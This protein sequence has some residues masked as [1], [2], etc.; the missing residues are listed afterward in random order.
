MDA[1]VYIGQGAYFLTLISFSLRNMDWLRAVAIVASALAI[2]YSA[3]ASSQPLW[4][5]IL[6]NSVF[7]LVNGIQLLL[8]RWR[9]RNV[10]LDPVESF[11]HK[12]VLG[13]FPPAEIKSFVKKASEGELPAG[14][15]LVHTGT[16]LKFLFCILKGKVEIFS[17][18]KK[19]AELGPGYFVGEM[20]LLTRSPTRADVTAKEN[21]KVLVWSHEEIEKWVDSDATRLSLL[22]T[23]LSTQVVDQLLRQNDEL[24]DRKKAG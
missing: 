19:T 7:I 10:W 23:A 6:W 2:Y 3:Y 13:S 1:F 9:K 8:T 20:S 18:H 14:K 16:D 15:Q 21:L 12:T 5:P 24:L 22:Q 17:N 11:L 4:I